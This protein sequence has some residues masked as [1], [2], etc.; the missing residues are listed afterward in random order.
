[1]TESGNPKDN[2]KAERINN[3][4]KNELLKGLVFTNI[5]EITTAVSEAVDFYNRERP[6]MSINMMTPSE[7]AGCTGEIKKKW[8]SYRDIAIKNR[9]ESLEIAVKALALPPVRGLLPGY[10]LQSTP[11]RDITR[12]DNLNQV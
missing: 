1:M 2:P 7:A 6:R 10:A 8:K 12:T 11:D 4:M 3:T 5:E 9:Q